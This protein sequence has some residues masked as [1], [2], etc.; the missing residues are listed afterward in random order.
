MSTQQPPAF[1]GGLV[2]T[3]AVAALASL[4]SFALVYA[5]SATNRG[6]ESAHGTARVHRTRQKKQRCSGGRDAAQPQCQREA[7][8]V[9]EQQ[10]SNAAKQQGSKAGKHQST[11][12]RRGSGGPSSRG[13]G[14]HRGCQSSG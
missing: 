5:G 2:T 7:A 11:D 12:K 13:V 14:A 9:E 10:R 8:A 1:S 3:G 4:A 6:K